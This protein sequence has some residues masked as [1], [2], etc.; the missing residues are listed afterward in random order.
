MKNVFH[1]TLKAPFLLKIFKFL[2][3]PI[4]HVEKWKSKTR[5]TSSNPQVTSSNPRV[6]SSNQRV[7]SWNPR[8]TS[9]N[10]RVRCQLRD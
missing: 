7:T 4:G 1:F 6:T 8:V 9:S 5:V 10:S 3:W 2:S